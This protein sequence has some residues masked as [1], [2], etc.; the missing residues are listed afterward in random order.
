[1]GLGSGISRGDE[2][3]TLQK[4][5]RLFE[6]ITKR[7]QAD[8]WE[9]A[10][11]EWH[12]DHIVIANDEDVVLGTYTCLCGHNPLKELCFIKNDI[13]D[14][15]VM[16]GNCCVKKFMEEL[17]SDKIFSAMKKRKVNKAAI[18]LAFAK[19]II[20]EHES[21]YCIKNMRKRKPGYVFEY[22]QRRVLRGLKLHKKTKIEEFERKMLETMDA[23]ARLELEHG[24]V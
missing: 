9:E 8:N 24:S 5:F 12:L 6:E 16:V 15:M 23:E 4:S 18:E 22:L 21:N 1:M 20:T 10:H 2:A 3:L 11:L 17:E 13:T 14:N 19:G 7:S